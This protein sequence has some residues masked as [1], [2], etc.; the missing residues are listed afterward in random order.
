MIVPKL[1]DINNA[2]K[3][4]ERY[5][6]KNY[7]EFWRFINDN[8][9]G[10]TFNERMYCYFHN[11]QEKPKCHTCG[12]DVR[13]INF[14]K[15][16]SNFCSKGCASKSDEVANKKRETLKRNYG[17]HFGDLMREKFQEKYGVDNP[18]QLE[19]VKA[20]IKETTKERYGVEHVRQLKSVVEQASI[21]AKKNNIEKYGVSHPMKLDTNKQKMFDTNLQKYG[22]KCSLQ[23]KDVD[24]KTKLTNLQKYGNERFTRTQLF[25]DK[26]TKTCLSRYGVSHYSKTSEFEEKYIDTCIKHYGVKNYSKTNE[27]T[28][29]VKLTSLLKYGSEYPMQSEIVQQKVKETKDKNHTHNTSSIEEQ[30]AS[31]LKDN[32]INF[33]RQYKSEQYPFCC[34]FYFPDRELYFEINGLWTHGSH[35]FDINN[36]T[37]IAK[38]EK[39][40]DKN[41]DYY[42]TAINTWT[43]R[44]PLKVK[45]AKENKLNFKVVYS[46]KL[47]EVIKE[48]NKK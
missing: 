35:P 18:Y 39:W 5:I 30:F 27:F 33:V 3:Q 23:N 19:S 25:L 47:D 32:N 29:K 21:T 12:K 48:Y 31:W 44:D 17:D 37:D 28:K 46:C 1:E 20:K 34:D 8:Y 11:I 10:D 4:N 38:L 13:F 41:T 42:D 26:Q 16:Y 7:E 22:T 9:A 40:K 14:V 15:G 45:T 2:A 6:K 43:V 24:E 36:E